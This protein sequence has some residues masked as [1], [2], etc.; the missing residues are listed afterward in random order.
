MARIGVITLQALDATDVFF[1]ED[2][3]R[4]GIPREE[5]NR[6]E[7]TEPGFDTERAWVNGSVPKVI[8]VEVSGDAAIIYGWFNG[9]FIAEYPFTVTVYVEYEEVEELIK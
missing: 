3:Y 2:V 5:E 7:L 8:P 9:Q 1:K 6:A 4:D